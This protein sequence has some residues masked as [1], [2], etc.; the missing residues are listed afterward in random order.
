MKRLFLAG[1]A[2]P[3]LFSCGCKNKAEPKQEAPHF[4]T[5]SAGELFELESKCNLLAQKV[6]ENKSLGSLLSESQV[7]HYN[8]D[9]NRCYVEF[10]SLDLRT[11]Q[12][13]MSLVDGQTGE[14]LASIFCEDRW[15]CSADVSDSSL[16]RMVKDPTAPS[17]IE[18]RGLMDKFVRAGRNVPKEQTP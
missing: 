1:A 15:N 2:L 16:K 14:E 9:D 13:S 12:D 5:R 17:A 10:K 8:P 6:L 11:A 18:V 3:L 7:S 4:P